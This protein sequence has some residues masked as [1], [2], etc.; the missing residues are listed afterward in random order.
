MRHM[1]ERMLNFGQ[2]VSV[3]GVALHRGIHLKCGLFMIEWNWAYVAPTM[4]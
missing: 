4:L 2:D 1:Q 3:E